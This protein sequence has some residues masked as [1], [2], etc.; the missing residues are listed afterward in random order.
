MNHSTIDFSIALGFVV[1]VVFFFLFLLFWRFVIFEFWLRIKKTSFKNLEIPK[2]PKIKDAEKT[3]TLART[4]STGVHNF[5]VVFFLFACFAQST[6]KKTHI[7]NVWSKYK[8]KTGPSMLR[9]IIGPIFHLLN[10]VFGLLFLLVVEKSF[11]FCTEN[12]TVENKQTK[13]KTLTSFNL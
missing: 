13:T 6:I 7:L 8:L 1:V 4:V 5:C 3:D 12:E 10:C 9:N 2:T 11:S